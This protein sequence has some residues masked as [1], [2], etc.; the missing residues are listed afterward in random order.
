ITLDQRSS[1]FAS[2]RSLPGETANS[3]SIESRSLEKQRRKRNRHRQ[4]WPIWEKMSITQ[5]INQSW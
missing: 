2:Q 3:R 5:I 4:N 1:I